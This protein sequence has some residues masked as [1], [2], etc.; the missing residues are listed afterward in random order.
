MPQRDSLA[1]LLETQRLCKDSRIRGCRAT[2]KDWAISRMLTVKPELLENLQHGQDHRDCGDDKPC[3]WIRALISGFPRAIRENWRFMILQQVCLDDSGKDPLAPCFVLAGYVGLAN[4]LMDLADRWEALLDK[5]PQLN[6]IK[7]YEAFGLNDQF[8]GWTPEERD[9]RLLPFVSLIAEYSGKGI[10]F[11]IDKKAFGMIK[12]LKDDYDQYFSDPYRFAYVLS[13]SSLLYLQ[14]GLGGNA[15]DV[16]FD[17]DVVSRRAAR[18][19][20]KEVFKT[21]PKDLVRRLARPEPHFE[22]DQKF[23]PLQAADLLAHCIRAHLDPTEPRYDRVR[24]SRVFEALRAIPIA[25]VPMDEGVF[26]Y[27]Q[28][29]LEKKAERRPNIFKAT[30][31]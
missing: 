24:Q 31:W 27:L 20:Y 29:R 4:D 7:G 5:D 8:S 11:T 3:L 17:Y 12:D 26:Q 9:R 19:A 14:E 22:D 21:W 28:E 16:V 25:L 15:I 6:Y 2:V 1:I 30:K 13:L 18:K 10:A 23:L